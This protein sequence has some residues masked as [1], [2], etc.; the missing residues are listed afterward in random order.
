MDVKKG[1]ESGESGPLKGP[2]TDGSM[3]RL[4]QCQCDI[5]LTCSKRGFGP[6]L[7]FQR[8]AVKVAAVSRR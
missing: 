7:W 5:F 6:K 3:K 8:G 1:T 2:D 4:M